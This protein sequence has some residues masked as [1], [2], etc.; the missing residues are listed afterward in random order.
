MTPCWQSSLHEGVLEARQ[1]EDPME[2]AMSGMQMLHPSSYRVKA[3]A[4][5]VDETLFGSPAGTRPS[6]PNFDPPW[7]QNCSR[8]RGLGTGQSKASVAKGDC[9]VTPSRGSTGTLTP[10][11]KNKYRL[12]SHTPS[13]CDESLFGFQSQGTSGAVSRTAVGDA[14]K[15]H[16]LFW[17]PPA[18]PRGGHSPQ[19]KETPLRA[20]HPAGPSRTEPR[21]ATGSRNLAQ[22]GLSAPCPLGQRCSHSLTHLS[23]PRR[24]HPATNA[25]HINKPADP[26]PSTAG[27]T[28]RNPLVTP[29]AR[30]GSVSGP[31]DPQRGTG[32]PKPKPPWR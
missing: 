2:L 7:V 16:A 6:P 12:I 14:A 1:H 23:V 9:E 5:Y 24:G 11:R 20:V 10:R 30:S 25:P 18:T 4:S 8:T 29:R 21:L 28:V 15:L 3:R 19:P 32:L 26:R 13:Y 31:A 27:V 17:T 22:D